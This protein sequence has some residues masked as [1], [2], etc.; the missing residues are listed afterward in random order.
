MEETFYYSQGR[1]IPV[2]RVQSG[3][4]VYSSDDRSLMYASLPG[5]S[6]LPLGVKNASLLLHVDVLPDR[7]KQIFRLEDLVNPLL[8]ADESIREKVKVDEERNF[9]NALGNLSF[10][11][12][13]GKG[14]GLL[15]PT[16]EVLVKFHS[17]DASLVKEKVEMLGGRIKEVFSLVSD[18]YCVE[19]VTQD[20]GVTLANTLAEQEFVEYAT[21][22]FIEEMPWRSVPPPPNSS[23]SSQWHLQNVGQNGARPDADVNA[24]KAWEI[25]TGSPNVTIC[26]IDSGIDSDH[27]A[28]SLPGKL[29]P[30]FDFVDVDVFPEPTSSSHGTSCA[31]VAAAPW[32]GSRTI[33]IAPGCSIMPIR[34]AKLSEHKK[35]VR[36]FEWAVQNN[37]D[38]ISC[39]FGYDNRPWILPD[40][41]RDA[42]D[43]AVKHG[44]G[45]K[46]CVIIWAAGNGSESIST[47]EWASYKN[48]I[49]VGASTDF[50]T[51]SSYSDYGPELDVCAPSS[52]GINSIV[53]TR[54]D[55]YTSNFGGTS[56]SAPLVAGIA[57]LLLSVNPNLKWNDVRDILRQSAVKIDR[58]N[59]NYSLTGHSHLYGYGRVDAYKALQKISV[60]T[61]AVRGTELEDR[62]EGYQRDLR[63]NVR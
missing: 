54:I 44:R 37:A 25:T 18:L 3:R 49:A 58:E 35:M 8:D 63:V 21:P 45:G 9:R 5:W 32:G 13:V 43:S 60:L 24:L 15:L 56:S 10:S 48:T 62:I 39:S 1:R 14:G 33:G 7:T 16:G 17:M 20:D 61:E 52:G 31:G 4:V 42:M 38:V 57:G 28:F 51:H 29:A 6:I 19:T 47:D 36:A 11:I 41:V 22:N 26:I 30:G 59:G 40:P 46:G 34:R 53:T 2:A 55:G 50:D 27:E 23:F 12:L